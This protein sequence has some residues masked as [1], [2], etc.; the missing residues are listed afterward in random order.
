MQAKFHKKLHL[1][2]I[3]GFWGH[4]S[5]YGSPCPAKIAEESARGRVEQFRPRLGA[6]AASHSS[7]EPRFFMKI[8]L[9]NRKQASK[10]DFSQK[11]ACQDTA[12]AL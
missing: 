7:P 6:F 10:N 11:K 5:A 4:F 3:L 12:S 1:W 9:K 2:I 8:G